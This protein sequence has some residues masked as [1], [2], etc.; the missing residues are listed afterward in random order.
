M[1]KLTLVLLCLFI[2]IGIMNAQSKASGIVLSGEDGQPIVGAAVV[3][4]GLSQGTVTDMDGRFTINLPANSKILQVSYVGM[5]TQDVEAK[6]NMRIVLEPN[7]QN[8]DEVV[9]TA[10]G[11]KKQEKALGYASSTVRN[12]ELVAAKSGS[13]MSGLSGKVAG[14][15]I[16]S[17]GGTGSSQKVI[18]RGLTSFS[19]NQPLYVV[20]GVPLM[21]DF[22]GSTK[23]DNSVD[24]GNGANDINPDDVESVTV[25]KGASATALYG[26]RAANGVIMITTKR[27]NADKMTVTYDGSFM[28][29]NVLR[30]PQTQDRWGQGWPDWNPM[31]NGS[32]GPTL[33]GR[34]H[35]WGPFSD[36]SAGSLTPLVK[37]FSYVKDNLRNFYQNGFEANNNVSIRKGNE[38]LGFV[39]SYGNV[40]SNGVLPLDADKYQRNTFS[41]RGNAKYKKFNIEANLN[42]VRK[43]ITR[44]STGQGGDGA[45]MFQ[46][47]LQN[48]TDVDI[49]SMWDYNNPYYNTD[50]YYTPYA[51]NP[52]F[53]LAKNK[54]KYQDDRIYGKL[55]LSY[56]ILNGLKAIGRLGGDFM[57]SRQRR[58]N[59]KVE[60]TPGSWSDMGGKNPEAGTYQEINEHFG[61]IDGQLLL[62]GNYAINKDININGLIGWNLNQRSYYKMDS[63]LYGLQQPGWYSLENGADKPLTTSYYQDRRLIGLFAQAEFDYKGFWYVNLSARNDWSSTLPKGKNSFF[64]GGVNTSLLLT[65]MFKDLK[66][67]WLTFLKVRGAWGKTGND[68]PVYRTSSYFVPTQ[69][70]LG[71]G[72]V[73]L[74]IDGVMGMT[75]FNRLPNTNLK[76]EIT[77]EWE[78]GAT[79]HFFQN[80]LNIDAAYY[81]KDTKDQII[82]AALA[83]ETRFTSMTRN[84]GQINNRG[85]ELTTNIVPVRTKDFEWDLGFTFSK[86]WSKV[87]KLWGDVQEYVLTS[88]Y[89]VDFVAKVGEPLG[90]FKVPKIARTEDGK[91]IVNSAGRPQIDAAAKETIGSSV[92]DF[93]MGF[94]TKFTWKDFSVGAVF[95]WR[96]GGYFYSYTSQLLTFTGNSTMTAFN[97]RQS[98][99]IPNSVKVING[100]YV[101]NDIPI[102]NSNV[103]NYWNNGSNTAM[104]S[105]WVLP[106]DYFKLR[107]LTISYNIPKRI[108][109]KTPFSAVQV[110][111]IGRNL[112]MWTAKRNNFVDPESTNYGNDINSELGEFATAPTT[113]TFGGGLKVTF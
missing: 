87:E 111:L 35:Q 93:L 100:K 86:N 69:I 42:Y 89:S 85:I 28:G 74:P 112:F 73:F 65:D 55:E 6:S 53:V 48:A 5:K 109:A 99:V 76:P 91:V 83:P 80:R 31:E 8:I 94:N 95:D 96:K 64:Y 29:S 104:Y 34:E 26:S 110:S 10:L 52:Y 82:S 16:T 15:N 40:A 60:Y 50:N 49:S 59:E 106:K 12:D 84:V 20:D 37:P 32:W 33:D 3:V 81:D 36:G 19:A 90:I 9:V 39:F 88:A 25:L 24:F 7:V 45:T 61:Q 4:K 58:W 72:N 68:A 102:S 51:S 46:E 21:N 70:G 56:D 101:E 108:L 13:L 62:Q 57:N 79:A 17:A 113:R 27:A 63:Y 77:T 107:E 38:N 54:N 92:P 67:D 103:Y 43:D 71:F 22:S 41:L 44:P 2:G 75:E 78:I 47:I 30:V 66:S 98:F 105:Q 97:N 23:T 11:M 14:L 18:V 1:R